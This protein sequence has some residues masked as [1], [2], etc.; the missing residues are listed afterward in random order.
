MNAIHHYQP[1]HSDQRFFPFLPFLAGLAV[2]PYI[3]RPR[4]YY[5]YPPYPY[6]T[7]YPPYPPYPYYYGR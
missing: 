7:P 6:Y 1:A 2:G 5:P 4:W 3:F